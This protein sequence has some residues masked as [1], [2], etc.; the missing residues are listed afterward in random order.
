MKKLELKNVVKTFPGVKAVQGVSFDISAGEIHGLIGANGA[1]KSTLVRILAGAETA[2]AGSV[3]VDEVENP[4]S[5]LLDIKNSYVGSIYQELTIIPHMSV[6]SNVFLGNLMT[7]HGMKDR[8]GMLRRFE[9][10]SELFN[11]DVDPYRAAG[12]LSLAFQQILEIMRVVN[13]KKRILIMDEPTAALGLKDRENFYELVS[14]LGREGIAVIFISHDLDEILKLCDRATVMREGKVV[15]TVQTKDIT[16]EQL[17][18]LMLG[19]QKTKYQHNSNRKVIRD[20][21]QISLRVTDLQVIGAKTAVN[22]TIYKGE[23][24]GIAGLVGSGRSEILRSIAGVDPIQSGTME[25]GSQPFVWPKSVSE[26][27]K[28]GIVF[29]PEDRKKD[30]L[31]PLRSAMQNIVMSNLRRTTK[32]G[33]FSINKLRMRLAESLAREVG[34]NEK[35]FDASA[36][37]LSGGNQQ[38]VVVAK[39]LSREPKV[40]LLDEPTRGIDIG[41][42]SE[43]FISVSELADEGMSAI[44]VSSDLEEVILHSDRVLVLVNGAIIKEFLKHEC[45]LDLVIRTIFSAT[46]DASTK[47]VLQ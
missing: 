12:G 35:Q 16:E 1:G 13:T 37:Q 41:A 2:D 3:Y 22:L 18:E 14:A 40:L 10:L 6:L 30:G 4:I 11:I 15:S 29:A 24:V 38:K 27:H 7:R 8:K 42:K 5:S 46:S 9:E 36:G 39:C 44:L 31:V 32:L 47:E 17:V 33:F 28:L 21:S 26:A 34:F 20:P 23:V 19:D 45:S 25:I 43:M